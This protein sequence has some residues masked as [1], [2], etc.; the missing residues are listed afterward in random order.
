MDV[1]TAGSGRRE[2]KKLT[3]RQQLAR[4]ALR[5]AVERGP[6]NVRRE[7]VADAADVSLR[8]FNNYFSS[9]EEAIVSLA[10]DRAA[11]IAPA[12]LARPSEESLADALTAAF[13]AQYTGRAEADEEWTAQIRVIVR[14]PALRGA[15][16]AALEGIE[17]SVSRA[18]AARAGAD[19]ER[20]LRPR[21]LAAAAC[22]AERVAI[23]CW[24]D[25]DG[26]IALLDVLRQALSVVLPSPRAEG[27][28]FPDLTTT[29]G[30]Q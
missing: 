16:L 30:V 25:S 18:I 9:K 29:G 13:V 17:D 11:T 12:L 23:D 22:S 24:L 6:A 19:H 2:R 26:A 5:L 8:T 15:Y 20:D 21:V 27:S 14:T 10:V 28:G 3:T 4:A 1:D 7:E